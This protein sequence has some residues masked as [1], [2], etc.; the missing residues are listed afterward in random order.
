MR[1]VA[2]R[3]R[4]KIS[5]VERIKRMINIPESLITRILQKKCILF[6]GAGATKESGG[7]LGR[8]LGKYIYNQIGDIGIDF[9][10]NLGRYTQLLV[11]KGYR[12]EIER[13]VRQRFSSLQPSSHFCNIAYIPWKAIY[14]TNYDDLV[15]KA[16][17][18]QRYYNYEV[19]TSLSIEQ[20]NGKAD[21]PIYKIN[22]DIN[23]P[24]S[25]VKPLVITLNDLRNNKT[26]NEKIISQLM[27]DMNDTFIFLGYSFQDENEIVRDIL[28]AFQKNERWESVKEKYVILPHIT[29]D[30]KL[31]L[32]SY[33][34]K[35]IRGTADE[36]FEHVGKKSKDNYKVKLA[37]LKKNYSSNEFLKN[38]DL[39]TLQYLSECF[40]VYDTDTFYPS[41][42]KYFYRGGHPNWGIIKEQFDISRNIK[43]Q[44][45]D[46]KEEL[47]TTDSL[48]MLIQKLLQNDRL[49]KIKLEGAAV[50]GKTTA[51]YRC[52][53]DLLTNGT[54]ALVFKQQSAYKKG[55]IYAIY[56]KVQEPF[57]IIIDDIFIDISE[58]IKMLD[59]AESNHLPILFFVSS[60][61]SDWA[62][63]LSNYNKSVLQP[64]DCV[65][66]MMDSFSS[67]EAQ[68]F[69]NKLISTN[70]IYAS[71]EYEKKGYIRNFQKNNNII[72]I[73]IELIDNG[74]FDKSLSNEY[75]NL[76]PE[77]Q[78]AYGIVSLIY[79]YGLKTK[80]EILQRTIANKYSFTWEDF[81]A[82]ILKNDAKGNL[83][84]DEIQGNYYILG[85]HRYICEKIVQIHFGGNYS[86]EISVFKEL[87]LACCGLEKDEHFIGSLINSILRDEKLYYSQTQIIDL[88][89]FAIDNFKYDYNCAFI[90]HLKGE[91]YLT[92]KDYRSAIRC[93]DSNVQ[94]KLNEEYSLH[95]LGKSYFYL[96]QHEDI[97][98]GEARMH[99]DL[100][101]DKLMTGLKKYN[102]NEYYYA[103]LISIYD[104]LERNNKLSEKNQISRTEMID[105][106]YRYIG[107]STLNL[108]FSEKGNSKITM[109]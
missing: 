102:Q 28:D 63:T 90:N 61:N 57:V 44:K 105:I 95:S 97:Q 41:D 30:V 18:K 94:N 36:F 54:L 16:Y 84:D 15:E 21:I 101:I 80:W 109:E 20:N 8:E 45:K 72:Q 32:E 82:K 7:A 108:L 104:Y 34:I 53:F 73:L 85:R 107:E 14:T 5:R 22:G 87:I 19:K 58:L 52:A 66:S 1:S 43:I 11:N 27:K 33:R 24:Y 59:E 4:L 12:D 92:L 67:D 99:F 70:I 42:G 76:C 68:K 75:D 17:S 48:F 35:Y 78:Y 77:T 26:N 89:N 55:L 64:F 10:E 6:L 81:I 50:S 103:L 98:S 46:M 39:Q 88:L 69:V 51:L 29:E 86:D 71:N 56:K 2:F 60:R 37:A 49:Q 106:A 62:N 3:K 13:L 65:I 79:K 23:L 25:P 31:D 100:A 83:Y 93:F 91:Y 9:K 40:D 38:L 74:E 96:A 47:S